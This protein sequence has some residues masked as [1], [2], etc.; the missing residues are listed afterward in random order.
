LGGALASIGIPKNSI[1]EYETQIKAGRFLV[2]ARD[3]KGELDSARAALEAT[4]HQG[5]THHS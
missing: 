5:V 1:L 4:K 2:I 3:A